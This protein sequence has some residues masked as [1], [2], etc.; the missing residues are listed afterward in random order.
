M[1]LIIRSGLYAIVFLQAALAFVLGGRKPKRPSA[2]CWRHHLTLVDFQV[3]LQKPLEIILE[4]GDGGSSGVQV[5]GIANDGS[6]SSSLIVP[7][8]VL[9]EVND[10]DVPTSDFEAIMDLLVATLIRW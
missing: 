10:V 4:E 9:L 5:K 3:E 6:A 1:K 7:G 2:T 8:D